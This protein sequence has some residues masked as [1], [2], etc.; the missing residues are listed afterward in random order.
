[1]NNNKR[2]IYVEKESMII[3]WLNIGWFFGRK[4]SANK[5][6]RNAM[7]VGRKVNKKTKERS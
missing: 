6:G 1:M 4:F 2:K 3:E 5:I 7:Q